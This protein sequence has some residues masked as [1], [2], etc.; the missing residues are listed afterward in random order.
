[1]SNTLGGEFTPTLNLLAAY[2]IMKR[3]YGMSMQEEDFIEEAYIAFKEINSVPVTY[4][5][6]TQKPNNPTDLLID[7]PC[8]VYRILSVTADTL[9][10]E[11]YQDLEPYKKE[12]YNYR[13]QNAEFMNTKYGN[14]ELKTYHFNDTPY[15][16]VGTYIHYSWVSDRQLKIEDK[17]LHDK[18]IHI[19][20]EGIAIDDEGLPLITRKHAQ[21][22]AIKVALVV[23][24]R[25]AFAGDAGIANMLPLLQ[26]EVGRLVQAAA[27]PEHITDNQLDKMLDVKTS[28]DRKRINRGLKFNR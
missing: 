19:V 20:Y 8:N 25:K 3:K 23:A 15:T 26:Q 1:M 18:Q 22:I 21:A 14:S 12:P 11:D 7:V 24:T 6:Y 13:E 28:F 27:I 5:Y 2:T 17:R 10:P 4:Y 9:H 16:G